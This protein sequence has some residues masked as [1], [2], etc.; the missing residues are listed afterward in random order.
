L[1][2]SGHVGPVV[3][4]A[5]RLLASGFATATLAAGPGAFAQAPPD[6]G[7]DAAPP[8]PVGF[9]A[10]E[11]QLDT[12]TQAVQAA[13]NVR[14]DEPPFHLTSDALTLHRVPI[15]VF[16]EGEGR[17][18]FCPCLGEP[19]AVRF[20]GAT[21][22]P[23]HDLILKDPV[24]EVFGIPIAWAPVF[25][26]RSPGR[27]G[28]L[29]PDLAWRGGDGFF[30]GGGVHLPWTQ[31]DLAHGLDL[32]AG[33]Y[34]QGGVA[35]DAALRTTATETRIRWD[36]LRGDDGVTIA[37]HGATAIADGTSPVDGEREDS[38]AWDVDALRGARA[39]TAT[40]DLDA[41]ARPFDRAAAQAAWRPDGWILGAG[42]RTVALRG[43]PVL[44]AGVGGPVVA[45]R[46]S[47]ALG[48]LGTYDA[49]VEGG[50]VGG[51]GV[52]ATSFARGEG[53]SLLA[54]RFGPLGGSLSFRGLG[55]VADDGQRSG[56]EG[57]AQAR[58]AL[59]LPLARAFAS[60]DPNDPWV[61]RTEPRI[62]AAAIAAHASDVL[63]VPPGRGFL[64]PFGDGAAWV[65]AAGWSNAFGRTGSRAAAEVDAVAGVIG[66]VTGVRPLLRG[67]ATASGPWVGLK[68]EVARVVPLGGLETGPL[69]AVGGAF[70]ATLRLGSA[71][72]LH[73]TANAAERD[74]VDP[75]VAR[76]LV[77]AVFEPASGF[78]SA[79]GWTGGARV[80][81]PLGSRIT[82]R[83][84]ADVDLS[85][86]D[87]VAAV[88]SLELH[89]P[90]GCVIVRAT[91][92][93]RIG[94]DGID[95]WVAVDLP[96]ATAAVH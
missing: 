70:L 45:I 69:D 6:A 30:A 52:G 21:L 77:D 11:L 63:V 42:V 93:H 28:L 41:A 13:G 67:T 31:G 7:P 94:R 15:G 59:S 23:P 81:L 38:I 87:L 61:H 51:D 57:V 44:D 83:G 26:L 9:G 78:L 34:V 4:A 50:Q 37:A 82:T 17:V 84:G 48:S 71:T 27:I 73:V 16:L 39:V 12:R 64:D 46:R 68:A 18:A 88:G 35:V 36:R 24:L 49:T 8:L 76:A 54:A 96:I 3:K 40:T 92:A 90:C 85:A 60:E 33:G 1:Y 89:D 20:K 10:D 32:R 72:G 25:W 55:D 47:D 74:G 75:V 56:M 80:G 53:G 43:S 65:A 66:D 58:A 19:L 91:A 29:P 14:V 2:S 5:R 62:E 79:T 95:A 22:A 86:G